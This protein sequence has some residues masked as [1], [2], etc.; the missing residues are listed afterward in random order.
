MLSTGLVAVSGQDLLS[1][2][3]LLPSYKNR[4]YRRIVSE[5]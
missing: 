3:V 1:V 5:V 4:V 2:S